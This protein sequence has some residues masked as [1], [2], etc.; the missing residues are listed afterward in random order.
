MCAWENGG[1]RHRRHRAKWVLEDLSSRQEKIGVVNRERL[2]EKGNET[3]DR[4]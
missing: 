1:V 3:E 4:Q 2:V